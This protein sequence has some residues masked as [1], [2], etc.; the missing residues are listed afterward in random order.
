MIGDYESSQGLLRLAASHS[1][2]ERKALATSMV[3]LLAEMEPNFNDREAALIGD[4]LNKLI[5][6]F[7]TAVRRELANRL[8]SLELA[9]HEVVVALAN[10]EIEVAK[11]LLLQSPALCDR[12]LIEIIQTRSRQHQMSITLREMVSEAVSDALVDTGDEAVITSLLGNKNA[13]ISDATLAYLVE[14]ARHVDSYQ[15]P[16]VLREDL[17][18]SLAKQIYSYVAEHLR[19]RILQR[20][21]LDPEVLDGELVSL[22]DDLVAKTSGLAND[23]PKPDA[24]DRLAEILANTKEITPDLLVKVLRAGKIDLFEAL[25]GQQT[26]LDAG[27]LQKVLY[28]ANGKALA[29]VCRAMG[30][31]KAQFIE[32]YLLIRRSRSND[33]ATPT[34]DV[35][36]IVRYFDRI[37]PATAL[38]ALAHW[39]GDCIAGVTDTADRADRNVR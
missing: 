8:A 26:G 19:T 10:D 27:T 22:P 20:F 35:G 24:R 7:E 23:K 16:L 3:D 14:E 33:S 21:D 39:R 15:E 34:R 38:E 5:K 11:P 17:S 18:D 36:T 31:P 2:S 6:D 30:I 1:A 13:Q 28:D 25:V 12:D 9:P 4:I 29:A 32:V 37:A